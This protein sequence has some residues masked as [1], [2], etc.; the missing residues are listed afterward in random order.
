MTDNDFNLAFVFYNS[1]ILEQIHEIRKFNVAKFICSLT[2]VEKV[3]TKAFVMPC[4]DNKIIKCS[5]IKSIDLS[6]WYMN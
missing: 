6:L 1:A 2:N 3:A 4:E 5:D